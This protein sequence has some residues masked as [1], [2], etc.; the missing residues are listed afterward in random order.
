MGMETL[1]GACIGIGLAAA[2]GMRVFIPLLVLGLASRAGLVTLSDSTQWLASTP[3]LWTLGVACL[4]EVIAYWLPSIDHALD[5]I[6]A[7]AALAAGTLAAAS[8]FGE[9]TPALSWGLG[10]IAGG[11]VAGLSAATSVSARGVGTATTAGLVNPL[12]SGVQ[13]AVSVVVSVLAVVVPVMLAAAGVI[14]LAAMVVLVRRVRR[15]DAHGIVA[16]G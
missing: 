11:G 9:F 7:P 2:C 16:T 12:I 5:V 15:S 1:V 3:A 4:V 6:A 8:Q 10:A 14:L 13:S